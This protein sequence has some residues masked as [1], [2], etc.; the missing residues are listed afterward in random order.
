MKITLLISTLLLILFAC[1]M[2]SDEDFKAIA[3]DTCDCINVFTSKLSPEMMEIIESSNGDESK[4][5]AA[6]MDY[7]TKDPVQ[8]MKDVQVLQGGENMQEMTAC[9]EGIEKKY[10]NV[11][12]TLSEDEIL[13]KII[14]QLKTMDDCKSTIAILKMGM[15]A[16]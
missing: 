14:E 16:R 13:S 8:G 7:M 2:S 6:M 4:L 9:M 11:Y 1:N 15:A 12:T 10:D 3:K 5:E